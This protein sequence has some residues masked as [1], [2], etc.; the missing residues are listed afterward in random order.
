MPLHFHLFS[1]SHLLWGIYF[2]SFQK[3]VRVLYFDI[4]DIGN[5]Y[6]KFII[7]FKLL[8]IKRLYLFILISLDIIIQIIEF[9]LQLNE[10]QKEDLV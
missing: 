5:I 4:Y 8:K 10:Y 1:L 3:N 6:A 7:F 2:F 9:C